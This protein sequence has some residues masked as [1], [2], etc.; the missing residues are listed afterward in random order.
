MDSNSLQVVLDWHCSFHHIDMRVQIGWSCMRMVGP[1]A[2]LLSFGMLIQGW[3]GY[4]W[5]IYTHVYHCLLVHG[6]VV[7]LAVPS[8][9]RVIALCTPF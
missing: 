6:V 3:L 4:T 2:V 5:L 8:G 7:C 1:D 9:A